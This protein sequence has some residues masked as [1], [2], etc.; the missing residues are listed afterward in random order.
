MTSFQLIGFLIL[1]VVLAAGSEIIKVYTKHISDTEAKHGDDEMTINTA[2]FTLVADITEQQDNRKS[3]TISIEQ[4]SDNCYNCSFYD[5]ARFNTKHHKNT[6]FSVDVQWPLTLKFIVEN[7]LNSCNTSI[8]YHFKEHCKYLVEL[9]VNVTRTVNETKFNCIAENVKELKSHVN[10]NIPILVLFAI[11]FAASLLYCITCIVIKKYN[12]FRDTS[13]SE[14]IQNEDNSLLVVNEPID[15]N[16]K[17]VTTSERIKSI[18]AFRGLSIIIMVFVNYKGGKYWFFHHSPWNGLTVA[19]LVFPWFMFIMGIS[20]TISI[21]SIIKKKVPIAQVMYKI[22]RRAVILMGIGLVISNA[23]KTWETMRIPGVLQRFAISYLITALLQYFFHVP[24]DQI[25]NE[26]LQAQGKS[27]FLNH[28][29]D[30]AFYWKQWVFVAAFEIIWL[31]L[32]FL[33]PVPGCPTGYIGPGGLSISNEYANCT[34]GSAGYIDQWIFGK[35]HMYSHPTCKDLYFPS[36]TK[37][38][39]IAFDPEGVLGSINSCLIVILG[40]QAGKIFLYFKS[41]SSRIKRFIIWGVVLGAIS[42][43][44]TKCSQD[45]GWIP[46]NKNLWSFSF[47]TTLSSFAFFIVAAM[48]YLIDVLEVWSGAPLYFVGMNS[49]LVYVGH[50]IF[51]IYILFSWGLTNY[52]SHAE[53]LAMSSLGA[54]YWVLISYYCYSVDF[55]LKI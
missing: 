50:E 7:S 6:S 29:K 17:P 16:A 34:G 35:N 31:C 25:T 13:P 19:D 49:I 18:D 54:F 48:Y 53:W 20:M 30:I 4:L 43:L 44:L 28:V 21:N 9:Q 15:E 27:A 47:V 36:Y 23:N 38:D 42:A 32:T 12:Q 3:P 11:L 41:P 10:S 5:V 24:A 45:N 22:F 46:V 51:S 2:L 39:K 52:S 33:M 37:N 26:N 40:L 55:F 1:T 8:H 14:N